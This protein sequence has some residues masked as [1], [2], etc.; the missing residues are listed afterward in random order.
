MKD[1]SWLTY[2]AVM[3]GMFLAAGLVFLLAERLLYRFGFIAGIVVVTGII[4]TWAW[5]HDRKVVE[6]ARRDYAE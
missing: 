2:A 3:V 5:F 1:R 4:L 6:Q